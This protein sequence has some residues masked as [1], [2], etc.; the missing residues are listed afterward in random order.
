MLRIEVKKGNINRALKELRYKFRNTKRLQRLKEL[1]YF[2][3]PS[4]K[5]RLE[6]EKAIRKDI[7]RR[8]EE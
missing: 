2:E 3:K 6:L 7:K 1:K 8:E 5:R 4:A